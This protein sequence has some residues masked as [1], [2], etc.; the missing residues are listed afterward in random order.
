M[1]VGVFSLVTTPASHFNIDPCLDAA[2]HPTFPVP[3]FSSRG[4]SVHHPGSLCSNFA[5]YAVDKL[6]FPSLPLGH[7]HYRALE[8]TRPAAAYRRGMDH[9][10]DHFDEVFPSVLSPRAPHLLHRFFETCL[11]GKWFRVSSS[12]WL[13]LLSQIT[14]SQPNE[15][16]P[17]Q[18]DH[19]SPRS[20]KLWTLGLRVDRGS[21][22]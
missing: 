9:L 20:G 7:N 3:P 15:G 16:P 18:V 22:G 12:S 6:C 17:F 21:V 5:L 19:S 13:V 2:G 11:M 14:K 10:H 4:R 1:D 8:P